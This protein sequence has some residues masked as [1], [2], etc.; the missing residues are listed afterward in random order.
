VLA[1]SIWMKAGSLTVGWVR[2]SDRLKQ[3]DSVYGVWSNV[4]VVSSGS[5][6]RS[7]TMGWVRF[8]VL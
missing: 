3:N 4:F 7:L 6:E 5:A 1:E 8:S 2:F